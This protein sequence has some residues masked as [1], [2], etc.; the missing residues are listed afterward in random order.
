MAL[1]EKQRVAFNKL[2]DRAKE[3]PLSIA[4]YQQLCYW[5]KL[6]Y[7]PGYS[8]EVGKIPEPIQ[9]ETVGNTGFRPDQLMRWIES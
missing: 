4:H 3:G 5:A 6:H 1:N 7:G 2:I 8:G 9:P